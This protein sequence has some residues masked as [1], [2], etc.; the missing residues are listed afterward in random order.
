MVGRERL[1]M[2]VLG[3]L[4][5]TNRRLIFLPYLYTLSWSPLIVD[6][7]A[8][9][10]VGPATIPWYRSISNLYTSTS[11]YFKVG[12]RVHFFT[13]LWGTDER[14][15]WVTAV[16]SAANVPFGQSRAF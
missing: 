14:N 12:K 7:G 15:D 5:L 16:S 1:L 9:E 6:L 13:S 2:E 3:L 11:W 8:I 10:S 4:Y